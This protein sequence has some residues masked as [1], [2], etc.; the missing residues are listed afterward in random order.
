MKLNLRQPLLLAFLLLSQV[1]LGQD[2]YS[3][4]DIVEA[5]HAASGGKAWRK[6]RSLELVG[7]A[8]FYK[9]GD[10]SQATRIDDYHMWRVFPDQSAEAHRA[11]GMVRFDAISD[12]QLVFQISY[13]GKHSYNQSG[14]IE[15]E[16]ANT[17]WQS[18]FGFGIIRFALDEGFELTRMADD[19]VD[20]HPS[21]MIQVRDAA[22]K[23]TLFGIDRSNFQ[24]RMVGFDTPKG[25]H[26]RIYDNFEW[27]RDPKFLQPTSVRLY[28]NG[29]KTNDITWYE[30]GVN[31]PIDPSLF[32]LQ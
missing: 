4:R 15:D 19:T 7:V 12:N 25:W 10:A 21:F 11:N 14:R 9:D 31:Q 8:T 5:A 23:D 26:H 20:G 6:P 29:V 16:A 24:I 30:Y 3:A 28:Y 13:D 1:A 2:D 27:H 18:N 17:R 22:G 32:T